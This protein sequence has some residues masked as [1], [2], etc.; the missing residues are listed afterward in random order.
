MIGVIADDLT[1]ASEIGGI[2]LRH[3]LKAEIILR[4]KFPPGADLL[5][6][7]TDSRSCSPREA[8][9]RAAAAA[10]KL[11]I[12]GAAWIYKKVDSVLRG[13]VVAEVQAIRQALELRSALLVPAN[14]CFGR[15]IRDGHYF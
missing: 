12:A 10:R 2:G 6:I 7:D 14:P 5:C 9:R 3:G 13:N 8:A 1:G 11:R 4:G 15:I